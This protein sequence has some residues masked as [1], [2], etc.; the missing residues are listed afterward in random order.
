VVNHNIN[1]S[2]LHSEVCARNL[3]YEPMA[4]GYRNN[5]SDIIF[6]FCFVFLFEM[7]STYH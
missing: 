2:A 3:I 6:V 7:S 5:V 1:K 4:T